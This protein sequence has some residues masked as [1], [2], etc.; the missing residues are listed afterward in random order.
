[1]VD[2]RTSCQIT[3]SLLTRAEPR[4]PLYR[5]RAHCT[6]MPHTVACR[7]HIDTGM[8]NALG[9]EPPRH[10]RAAGVLHEGHRL[11]S[12]DERTPA[13]RSLWGS[14]LTR[15]VAGKVIT[16]SGLQ[17]SP[18]RDLDEGD[19]AMGET[20]AHLGRML[21]FG[22]HHHAFARRDH[23]L[24]GGPRSEGRE[25][26]AGHCLPPAVLDPTRPRSNHGVPLLPHDGVRTAEL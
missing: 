5:L 6:A 3:A 7:P 4:V 21:R 1:V 24:R 17:R 16:A 9:G 25:Y 11:A 19:G 23:G 15:V 13:R 8:D 20:R 10:R 22:S 26:S 14:E 12:S 18:R 2:R